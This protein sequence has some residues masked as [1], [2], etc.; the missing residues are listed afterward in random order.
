MADKLEKEIEGLLLQGKSKKEIL[1][2]FNKQE[3]TDEEKSH[4]VI[5]FLNNSAT[6]YHRKKMMTATL[7]LSA[8]LLFITAKKLLAAFSFGTI[9]IY[10]MLGL[11]VPM[12]NFYVLREILRFHRL[13]FKFLFILSILSLIQPE[14]HHL[15]EIAILTV[16]TGL[17]G[18]LY[19]KMFPENEQITK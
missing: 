7:A 3:A 18:F 11:V 15:Q 17:S 16:M 10:L 19:K 13:G 2:Y 5:F 6:L 9:D 14:N 12:I 1:G 4:K 8:A